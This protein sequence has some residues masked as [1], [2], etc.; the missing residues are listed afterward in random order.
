[1]EKKRLLIIILCLLHICAFGQSQEVSP[2]LKPFEFT[3]G[4]W[5]FSWHHLDAR[6][7]KYVDD[8]KA[9]STVTLIHDGMT[10]ADEFYKKNADGSEVRGTTFRGYDPVSKKLTLVWMVA[11]SLSTVS[12]TGS[13]EGDRVV[14]T[15]DKEI[16]DQYGNYLV[17]ITFYD[18]QKDSYKWKQDFI[19]KDGTIVEKTSF[20]EARRIE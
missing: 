19:Y 7:R 15:F 16:N 6:T 13:Q 17:R 3:L 8:G 12:A 10:Y 4:T 5:E 2:E 18:I 14:L 11:G 9:Y 20:Y 1:M